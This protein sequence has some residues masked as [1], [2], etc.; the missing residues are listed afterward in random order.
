MHPFF[1]SLH[2]APK[3]A[4]DQR[5]CT[6]DPDIF[7]IV[8][9]LVIP[10]KMGKVAFIQAWVV[11][12][13]VV[14]LAFSG[15]EPQ[16]PKNNDGEEKQQKYGRGILKHDPF[17]EEGNQKNQRK[18]AGNETPQQPGKLLRQGIKPG[19]PSRCRAVSWRGW[20]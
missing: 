13:P 18:D 10:Q 5:L 7:S 17:R 3:L 19:A 14:F 20:R 1:F 2:I 11:Q 4:L 6:V 15:A 16:I 12:K 9:I 8:V